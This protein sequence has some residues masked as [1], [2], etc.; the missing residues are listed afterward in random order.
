MQ[1]LAVGQLRLQ[2]VVLILSALKRGPHPF[3]FEVWNKCDEYV[4]SLE[5]TEF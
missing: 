2:C 1:D 4:V 3:M 5:N